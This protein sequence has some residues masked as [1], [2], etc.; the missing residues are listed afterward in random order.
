M[1]QQKGKSVSRLVAN[2]MMEHMGPNAKD[3]IDIALTNISPGR[4]IKDTNTFL[5]TLLNKI[6]LGLMPEN[7][8]NKANCG[9]YISSEYTLI[10]PTDIMID[11][12]Q[13]GNEQNVSCRSA[14]RE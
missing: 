2:L 8:P 14:Y 3:I 7:D 13:K 12:L 5:I 9:F 6:R 10:Y 1:V 11:V 4:G